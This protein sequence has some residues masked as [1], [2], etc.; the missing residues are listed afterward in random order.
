MLGTRVS[1]GRF[2]RHNACNFL[3]FLSLLTR[4]L[5]KLPNFVVQGIYLGSQ[6]IYLELLVGNNVPAVRIII[7][8]LL[9]DCDGFVEAA[10]GSVSFVADLIKLSLDER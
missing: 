10:D 4:I 7:L 1:M 5:F 2:S 3:D 6:G 8:E 9:V